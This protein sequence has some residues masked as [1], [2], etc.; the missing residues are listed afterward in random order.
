[1]NTAVIVETRK[2]HN[3]RD[4]INNHFRYLNKDW[5]LFVFHG[6]ENGYLFMEYKANLIKLKEDIGK[7]YPNGNHQGYNNLLTSKW[8]WESVPHEKIL[9][10]QHDS[11]LLRAGIEEFLEWDYIGA[12]IKNVPDVQ[13]GGLSLRSKSVM[14][15]ILKNTNFAAN[16][17]TEDTFF[18]RNIKRFGKLAPNN[19]A[20][21]FSVETIFALGSLGYHAINKYLNN[22]QCKTIKEQYKVKSSKDDFLRYYPNFG[23]DVKL[24]KHGEYKKHFNEERYLFDNMD[25]MDAIKN[26]IFK[27][28]FE[29]YVK[30]GFQEHRLAFIYNAEEVHLFDT[31]GEFKKSFN[32]ED[33]F[34]ENPDVRN[35]VEN[36]EFKNAYDHYRKYGYFEGRVK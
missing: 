20:R 21:Q 3:I 26:G 22:N 19:I 1:M 32:E 18:C 33:Y 4:I 12:P 36:G 34:D 15:N 30:Y 7:G 27:S 24:G 6:P 31:P 8:F 13:N 29:H 11:G 23:A 9:I 28:G 25:V 10:F 14:L 5:E 2:L 35:A 16:Y 17:T